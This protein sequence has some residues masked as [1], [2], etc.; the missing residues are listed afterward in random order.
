MN[1]KNERKRKVAIGIAGLGV[2]GLAISA[3]ATLNLNWQGNFEAGAIEVGAQCQD[4]V[5]VDV[6]FG[7]PQFSASASVPWAVNTLEFTGV[8][9]NC[10][11]K[12]YAVAIKTDADWIEIVD[13]GTVSGTSIST[14]LTSHDAEDV[15]EV[16]LT[17]FD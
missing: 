7:T 17:I 5:A 1:K 16:A 9:E 4:G 10:E 11:A 14:P 8:A 12:N 15:T 3:A 6:R 2:A 13:Q